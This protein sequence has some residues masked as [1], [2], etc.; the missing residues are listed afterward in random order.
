MLVGGRIR[1]P[2]LDLNN[3][4]P[5]WV[6]SGV[7]WAGLAGLLGWQ[8]LHFPPQLSAAELAAF[9]Q[10]QAAATKAGIIQLPGQADGWP[11]WLLM[12]NSISFLH[13]YGLL[14]LVPL[15]LLAAAAGLL[16]LTLRRWYNRLFA[17][18]GTLLF[19]A[20]LLAATNGLTISSA[21]LV[22]LANCLVLYTLTVLK[23]Q[24]EKGFILLPGIIGLGLYLNIYGWLLSVGSGL[25]AIYILRHIR[26]SRLPRTSWLGAASLLLVSLGPVILI[27]I[28]QGWSRWVIPTWAQ[29]GENL[30]NTASWLVVGANNN[31][32]WPSSWP[33]LSVAGLVLAGLGL[34]RLVKHHQPHRFRAVFGLL[35]VGFVPLAWLGLE[36]SA[37]ASLYVPLLLSVLIGARFLYQQWYST[38]PRNLIGRTV[39][40]VMFVSIIAVMSVFQAGRFWYW[41]HT[42]EA[43]ALYTNSP[44]EIIKSR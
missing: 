26:I 29:L 12:L 10:Q 38:F 44:V 37:A 32:G 36:P 34:Y 30:H 21:S 16:F 9:E 8:L 27:T 13:H 4:F 31:F 40:A 20:G 1:H 25:A 11:F 23:Q 39:G 22:L 19:A 6:L 28:Q 42:T 43:R 41:P 14:R 15:L 2:F 5:P 7:F 3:A 33:L 18:A 24:P 35:L 17:Y